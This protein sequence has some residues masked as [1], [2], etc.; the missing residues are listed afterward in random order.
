MFPDP[1]RLSCHETSPDAE[2]ELVFWVLVLLHISVDL[3][4]E[5][6]V[7]AASGV[8]RKANVD[9]TLSSSNRLSSRECGSNRRSSILTPIFPKLEEGLGCRAVGLLS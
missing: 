6:G 7:G 2:N 5:G 8:G 1:S 3:R 9:L 4:Q